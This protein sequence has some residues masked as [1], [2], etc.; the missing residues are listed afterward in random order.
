M[1][2]QKKR[3][4]GVDAP[5]SSGIRA[6]AL[7]AG[8]LGCAL[9]CAPAASHAASAL[10]ALVAS[11]EGSSRLDTQKL[12]AAYRE[13]L[14]RGEGA[15]RTVARLRAYADGLR[16]GPLERSNCY[17]AAAHLLWREGDADRALEFADRALESEATLDGV[18]FKARLL[19][20]RG[21][22]QAAR[23]WFLRAGGAAEGVDERWPIRVRLAMMETT[24]SDAQKL[25]DLAAERDQALRNQIAMVLALLGRPERA[26]ALYR[27]LEETGPLFRQHL[28]LAEWAS[29]A[30]EH[31][32]AREHAWLAYG[33]ASLREDKLYALALIAESYREAGQLDLLIDDLE[34][35]PAGDDELMRLRIDTLVET[36]QYAKAID[37]YRQP[38]G[39]EVSPDARRRLIDFYRLAGDTGAM[40][41][42]Y[43][44]LMEAEPDAVHWYDGLAS[45]YVNQADN[46]SALD[47][48][49]LLEDRNPH[50]PEVLVTAAWSMVQMGFRA[51]SADMIE[52]YLQASGPDAGALTFLFEAWLDGGNERYAYEALLRLE[53]FLPP[54]AAELRDLAEAYERLNVPTEAVRIYEAIR[55]SGA[56][57]GYDEQLRL[58]W[59]YEIV[60]RRHDALSLYRQLWAEAENPARRSLVEGRFLELAARLGAVGD[61]VAELEGLLANGAAS[62]P[63]I[64]LLVRIYVQT[65]DELAAIEIIE[66]YSAA[67]GATETSR[68]EQLARAYRLM[69]NY[70]GHD[71]ALRRL[72][73]VDS[74]NREVHARNII[75]NMLTHDLASGSNRRF[76]EIGHW[77]GEL[78]R[79]DPQGVRGEFEASVYSLAGFEEEA[80]RSY[81][82]A[83]AEQPENSENLL[84][85]AD[86][87]NSGG[88]GGEAVAMLQ[89]YAENAVDDNDFV[90]AVDGLINL[91]GPRTFGRTPAGGAAAILDWTR[92]VILERIAD[93][94]DRFYLYELLAQIARETGDTEASFSALESSLAEAGLRR[95]AILRELLTMATP[96]TG[97][98]GYSTG[99]GD[100]ARQLKHG[101]RL[102]ALRQHL[103]PEVHIQIGRTLLQSGDVKG[104]ERALEM[105]DDVSGLV[106]IDLAKAEMF[107]Q[108]GRFEESQAYYNR[109]YN[110]NRDSLELMHKTALLLESGGSDERA[111]RR[112]LAALQLL[113][114]RQAVWS[115]GERATYRG[116]P[117]NYGIASHV[118]RDFRDY[119][120]SLEHGLLL[121][122][123]ADRLVA[124]R[125]VSAL[126]ELF[127]GELR[128]VLES[129]QKGLWPL[130]NYPALE[131]AAR[132]LRRAG[133]FLNDADIAH[134]PDMRLLEHFAGDQAFV[135]SLRNHYRAAGQ[136]QPELL[137]TQAADDPVSGTVASRPLDRQL[138]K[139]KSQRQY[140]AQLQ[141]LRLTG[142]AEEIRALLE[143]WITAGNLRDGLG[144]ALALLDETEFRQFAREVA[145]TLVDKP[146]RLLSLLARQAGILLEA[147]RIAGRSLVP[148]REILNLLLDDQARE[149]PYG[150][151]LARSGASGFWDYLE[152]RAGID[153]RIR[154][155]QVVTEHAGTAWALESGGDHQPLRSLLQLPLTGRQR[156]DIEKA[157]TGYL[158]RLN[159]GTENNVFNVTQSLLI[160]DAHADNAGVLCRIA[161]FAHE[162]IP[163]AP[164][165]KPLLEAF[166]EDRPE[167]VFQQVVE[168]SQT[169]SQ[170]EYLLRS[171]PGLADAMAGMGSRLLDLVKSGTRIA[172]EVAHKAY[173]TQFESHYGYQRYRTSQLK[174]ATLERLRSLYPDDERYRFE[175][176]EAW[177]QSGNQRRAARMFVREHL[178]A[179][180]D[181][182]TWR[183][184]LFLLMISQQR[185]EEALAVATDGGPDLRD[186]QVREDAK[187]RV[188]G[189]AQAGPATI[190]L[191]SFAGLPVPPGPVDDFY[192]AA[193]SADQYAIDR[194]SEALESGNHEQ[195]RLGF[196][197][198]WR[199]LLAGEHSH[200]AGRGGAQR[201]QSA[202]NSLLAI[203]ISAPDSSIAAPVSLNYGLASTGA[204]I[205]RWKTLLAAVADAPFGAPELEGY[206]RALPAEGRRESPQL[207]K[208]LAQAFRANGGGAERLRSLGTG[209]RA[210]A[211]DDHDFMLWML[212]HDR[213]GVAVSGEELAA[214]ELRLAGVSDPTPYQLLLAA[215]VYAAAGAAAQAVEYYK[216]VAVNR[217]R[218]EGS[219]SR[220]NLAHYSAYHGRELIDLSALIEEAAARLPLEAARE[221]LDAVLLL[222]ARRDN[223]PAADAMF[224]TF[225][226][227]SLGKLYP[228]A[229]ALA[230]AR[231]RF[232]DALRLPERLEGAGVVKAIE[233]ARAH[234]RAGDSERFIEV[235]RAML[236]VSEA[237]PRRSRVI[238][239]DEARSENAVRTL[240]EMYGIPVSSRQLSLAA[241]LRLQRQNALM[242]GNE[243]VADGL[244]L[245]GTTAGLLLRWLE[246][247]ELDSDSIAQ[248]LMAEVLRLQEAGNAER[249]RRL[250]EGTLAAAAGRT[251]DASN[252][253]IAV[254]LVRVLGATAPVEFVAGVLERGLLNEEQLQALLEAYDDPDLA[255]R[256]LEAARSSGLDQGLA[257]ITRLHALAERSGN[258]ALAEEWRRRIVREESARNELFEDWAD[259]P[260]AGAIILH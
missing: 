81:R 117:G 196:R 116:N 193:K 178:A 96:F 146:D 70:S 65:R 135:E 198:I 92:R 41:G 154:Y 12:D 231:R 120:D 194:V 200:T 104:A 98:G 9:L 257:V 58:A 103:P 150:T 213:A 228:P 91:S 142:A 259:A 248:L 221:M 205:P 202:V 33:E 39:T 234:S 108:A 206:L 136:P 60:E 149:S 88:R 28:R 244:E 125:V 140:Y 226:L 62:R 236:T 86:L 141:L 187:Q 235:L 48:W 14:L 23:D 148:P 57:L 245:P 183:T 156:R 67:T 251:L 158:L 64:D 90:V 169:M 258:K 72:Y 133:F 207:Y 105:M 237:D 204:A 49:Y 165:L 138:E 152:A 79:I 18:L 161:E 210:P 122:W 128:T 3:R 185:F 191:V 20:A 215:R 47:V 2:R 139:D 132:L 145:P 99:M 113:L 219:A 159:P 35:V 220:L 118:S 75:L 167:T 107:E 243:R 42:E 163:D 110:L 80:I 131:S 94:A 229:E 71:R 51:E 147:E 13:A 124:S 157:V 176:T 32:R 208:Y 56:D 85:M 10:A 175:L 180:E 137:A 74:E 153:E 168:L 255:N 17:L 106:D 170:I 77:I 246:Q 233:Q 252:L 238:G 53:Q 89:Y 127:D 97:Y 166:Y 27:P 38:G 52:N 15:G 123:P 4:S 109:A 230:E 115:R 111:F 203:R 66:E 184:L 240:G 174:A 151:G 224:D 31:E 21:E 19:D 186:R 181:D 50:R 177:L 54:G 95:P 5:S 227:K 195:G 63:D 155:L 16:R 199:N 173:E 247:G 143:E 172:P 197:R 239:R 84:L 8:I 25:E 100:P 87:M 46:D 201:L 1:L 69:E 218:H 130:A 129:S 241:T 160:L 112:Y 121:T 73:E 29:R 253:A 254:S 162:H 78:R 30:G 101:R 134:Y 256:M 225:A 26:I 260:A 212:L 76:E 34:A 250:L 7:I 222:A 24:R 190:A 11:L 232:P 61:V 36:G 179:P 242:E 211:M 182:A 44:R 55:D 119:Y 209:L 171:R 93:R 223:I 83:L 68:L 43:R 188:L 217:I 59:L 216:M 214:F 114:G 189:V 144:Y 82:R 40:V 45:H 126:Q 37:L 22:G 6:H 192:T 249:A 164:D 102:V